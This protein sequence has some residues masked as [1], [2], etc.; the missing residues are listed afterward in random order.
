ME[1]VRIEVARINLCS[2]VMVFSVILRGK[3]VNIKV[4]IKNDQAGREVVANNNHCAN[5][6]ERTAN[7]ENGKKRNK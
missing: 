5:L 7:I 4:C 1:Y 6:K 2:E 3:N